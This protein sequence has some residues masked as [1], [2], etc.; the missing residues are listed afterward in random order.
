MFIDLGYKVQDR[1]TGFTGIVTGLVDYITGCTQALVTGP[2]KPD[3]CMG[4]SHWIDRERLKVV[5]GTVLNLD[6]DDLV[7]VVP[8]TKR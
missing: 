7:S 4:E 8:P 1:I 6:E 5:D 2:V 3:G